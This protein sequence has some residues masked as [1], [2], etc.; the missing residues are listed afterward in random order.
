MKMKWWLKEFF[1]DLYSWEFS[2]QYRKRKSVLSKP[3]YPYCDRN[4]SWCAPNGVRV[5]LFEPAPRE[6]K[7]RK[8][9]SKIKSKRLL[10]RETYVIQLNLFL[11]TQFVKNGCTYC[12]MYLNRDMDFHRLTSAVLWLVN[13]LPKKLQK[14][15][16]PSDLHVKFT[17][18]IYTFSQK[19][20][21]YF[22][23]NIKS[24][25]G[26]V[27]FPAFPKSWKSW[28][29]SIQLNRFPEVPMLLYGA[30]VLWYTYSSI[31]Y[32]VHTLDST[33]I[34]F[35]YVKWSTYIEFEYIFKVIRSKK[36]VHKSKERK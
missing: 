14:S 10:K 18:S 7:A 6:L 34:E 5:R 11:H 3:C 16:K 15:I 23:P 26:R 31:Q 4:L 21:D 17:I 35:E 27:I 24:Q 29:I 9:P 2:V 20:L 36:T 12:Q 30:F 33:Y 1:D 28:T 8:A 32:T 22:L 13:D 25:P 19:S